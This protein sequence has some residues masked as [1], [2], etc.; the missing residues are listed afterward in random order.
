MVS[1]SPPASKARR[2]LFRLGIALGVFVFGLEIGLRLLPPYLPLWIANDLVQ[3]YSPRVGGM[4]F[5]DSQT[6]M[7]FCYPNDHRW[8]LFNGYRWLHETDARGNRNPSDTGSEVLLLGDS[9]IYGHCLEEV[10]TLGAILR[11]DYGWKAYNLARQGDSLTQQYIQFRLY[12]D[13]LK[14]AKVLLFPFVNDFGDIAARKGE[15]PDPK[16]ELNID[17]AAL[18]QRKENPKFWKVSGHWYDH[19]YTY[20]LL[21]LMERYLQRQKPA[22][23][24]GKVRGWATALT[25]PEERE[26]LERYYEALLVDML[27]R[28]QRGGAELSVIFIHT[29]TPADPWPQT[30]ALMNEVLQRLCSRHQIPYVSAES[31]LKGH[32]E[33]SLPNDGHLTRQGHEALARFVVE[34]AKKREKK[35]GAL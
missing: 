27:Q 31:L 13:E 8:C 33:Y 14:P 1:P 21:A 28:C 20:R 15:R 17:F 25:E 16:V 2:L 26:P 35:S 11:R 23:A 22:A 9:F 5:R 24:G 7:Y 32:P 30:Q 19:F 4:Y 29:D 6:Q 10:D 18:R 12:F 3:A 34:Q